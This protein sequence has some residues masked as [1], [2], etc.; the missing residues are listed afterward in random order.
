MKTY[1]GDR[2]TRGCIV[3]VDGK[4]L[5]P[6][7]DLSGNATTAFDW[8]YVGGGQ[9]ALAL[10]ADYFGDDRKAKAMAEAFE[11]AV[12]AELHRFRW[13][14]NESDMAAALAPLMGVDG[15]R[16][17]DTRPGAGTSFAEL[18]VQTPQ[19]A[20][21]SVDARNK[22]TD[23]MVNAANRI[24]DVARTVAVTAQRA[25]AHAH[26]KPADEAMSTANRAADHKAYAANRAADEAA[27]QARK[28]VADAKGGT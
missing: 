2:T 18:P 28:A 21:N 3:T 25:A 24:A 20:S 27:T 7:S 11:K 9:L 6:R 12:I 26:D 5:Q 8:G 22:A 10:L 16:A 1:H 15:E 19:V 17:L 14:M 4:P 13:T 23:D